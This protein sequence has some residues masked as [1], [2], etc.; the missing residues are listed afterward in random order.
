MKMIEFSR[1]K[2]GLKSPRARAFLALGILY[3]VLVKLILSIAYW[4]L[5]ENQFGDTF[6]SLAVLELLLAFLAIFICAKFGK[7]TNSQLGTF[8]SRFLKAAHLIRK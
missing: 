8:F 6:F 2:E 4:T 5:K 3:I 7:L 1:M